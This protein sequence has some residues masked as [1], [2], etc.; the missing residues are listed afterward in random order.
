MNEFPPEMTDEEVDATLAADDGA[1]SFAGRNLNHKSICESDLQGADFRGAF[2][3]KGALD[4][5]NLANARF[6]GA[7]LF[8]L[9][10]IGSNCANAS[11]RGARIEL[12][13]LSESNFAGAD[14]SGA[15]LDRAV[16]RGAVFDSRTRFDGA[17][18]VPTPPRFIIVDGERLD[19]DE[20]NRWLRERIAPNKAEEAA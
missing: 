18:G 11:F 8:R 20:A 3:I 4:E 17:Y 1:P 19:G 16:F 13:G 2:V 6:D 12:A 14:F 5:N 15:N 10:M 9:S 7:N